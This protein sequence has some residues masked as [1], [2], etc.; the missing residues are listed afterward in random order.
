MARCSSASSPAH[1]STRP[2]TSMYCA[3][4]RTIGS[5]WSSRNNPRTMAFNRLLG[6]HAKE[7]IP[8]G[9]RIASTHPIVDQ[10]SLHGLHGRNHSCLPLPLRPNELPLFLRRR[11]RDDADRGMD[12]ETRALLCGTCWHLLAADV[13]GGRFHGRV[14]WV[15]PDRANGLH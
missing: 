3:T 5:P 13:V 8:H 14:I 2:W 12:R 10:D 7:R 4:A 11:D 1:R 9:Q 6:P 15:P